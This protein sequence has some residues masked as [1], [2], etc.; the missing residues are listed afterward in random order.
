M[1]HGYNRGPYISAVLLRFVRTV[2]T[3]IDQFLP[4]LNY[5]KNQLVER[6]KKHNYIIYGL[7]NLIPSFLIKLNPNS[8]D[9]KKCINFTKAF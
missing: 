8:N 7:Q 4:F 9:F 2:G 5:F 3:T 6:F 1:P